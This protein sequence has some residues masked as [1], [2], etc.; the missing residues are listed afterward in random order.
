[1]NDPLGLN[2]EPNNEI[3]ALKQRIQELENSEAERKRMEEELLASRNRLSRA[4]MVSRCGHWEFDFGARRVF[5]SEGARSIYGL[6]DREWTIQEVQE[7]PLP[8]YRDMLDGALRGLIEKNRPY[9]VAFKIRRPDTGEIVDIYSVAEYDS[10]R[11]V[12]F[13]IIQD[14]T[15]RSRAEETLRWKTA[16]LE[17]QVNT[18]IDGIL[19]V[20]ENNRRIISNRRLADFWDV[21]QHILDDEDDAALL[22]HVVSLVKYPEAFLEKVMYLY[23]HPHE[24]SRDEVEFK[25]GMVLD[26]Y[27]APVVGADGRYY[28]RIW[29]FRDIT[30]RKQVEEA[31]QKSEER[32]RLA[33]KGGRLAAWDWHI[34][35]G[36]VIWNDEHYLM[37]GYDH[38]TIIPSYDA[39]RDRVHPEDVAAIEAQ[40]R[41]DAEQGGEHAAEYRILWPNGT[42]RWMESRCCHEHDPKGK[43]A[44]SYGVITDITERKQAEEALKK[45][46]A[47]FRSYLERSPLAVFVADK[48]G[49]LV[50]VNRSAAELLGYDMARLSCMHIWELYPAADREEVRREFALLCTEARIDTERRFQRRDG[51]HIWVSLHAAM[52]EGGFSLA[53]CWDITRQKQA[54]E[55]MRWYELLSGNSRDIILFMERDT[56]NI[57]E[58]NEA[59]ERAYG[60]SREELLKLTITDLCAEECVESIACLMAKGDEQGSLFE[61]IHRRNDGS[62]FPVEVSTRTAET[63][64]SPTLINIV[65]DITERKRMEA[66]ILQS[67]EELRSLAGHLSAIREDEKAKIARELHDELGQSLTVVSY[68]LHW[69]RK[70]LRKDQGTLAEKIDAVAATTK[71]TIET[72]KRIQGELR[73]SILDNLGLCETMDWQARQFT[74]RTHIPVAFDW[75][76]DTVIDSKVAVALYR[77]F[78]EALTNVARHSGATEIWVELAQD[79]NE[80]RLSISDDGRGIGKDELRKP[81]SF[82][83]L[84][85]KERVE[86]FSGSL[87]V[88]GTPGKGTTLKVRIPRNSTQ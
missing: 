5:A 66:E 30:D 53:Y 11:N 15:D 1:M 63:N 6:R 2:Q 85:M 48:E 33:L 79:D 52:I 59:A 47:K 86:A 34:A 68:D 60:Y 23:D 32:F 26:R 25:N 56:G 55:I 41:K 9:S 19:V 44:R 22:Q 10:A 24:A 76:H 57:I 3:A 4:E 61:A 87:I 17:A 74:E 16:L 27:S 39:W 65:R 81:L 67:R 50:Q 13:G 18:S 35:S 14:I 83:L 54:E 80:V 31:L 43:P 75:D 7:I 73:P 64:G 42:V 40:L 28:G 82:G 51:S 70:K 46:E 78:Q 21:P 49:Q 69:V 36:E 77:I 12:V 84:G 62:I 58:A 88:Q 20:D 45:S 72:I 38:G 8:E 37:F 71:G 29:T